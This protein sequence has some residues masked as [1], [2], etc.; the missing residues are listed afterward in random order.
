[1]EIIIFMNIL[2]QMEIMMIETSKDLK[3]S[4]K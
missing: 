4:E 3:S 2:E 1:M